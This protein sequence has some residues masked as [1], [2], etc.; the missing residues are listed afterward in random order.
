[1]KLTNNKQN[2]YKNVSNLID[3]VFLRIYLFTEAPDES[4]NSLVT[5]DNSVIS[6]HFS[7]VHR[8]CVKVNYLSKR[9]KTH[10]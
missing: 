3:N 2:K 9:F 5:Q 1:M 6:N 4:L 8:K 7:S 10:L